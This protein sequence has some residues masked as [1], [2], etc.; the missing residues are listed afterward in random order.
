ME[1]RKKGKEA[2]TDVRAWRAAMSGQIVWY[3]E[4]KKV[5]SNIDK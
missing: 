1:K 2:E 3:G 4:K 5:E